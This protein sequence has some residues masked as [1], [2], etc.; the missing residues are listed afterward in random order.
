MFIGAVRTVIVSIVDLAQH[1]GVPVFACVSRDFVR[2]HV[3]V[4]FIRTVLAVDT[5]VVDPHAGDCLPVAA[6]PVIADEDRFV[7]AVGAVRF[8]VVH[9]F[10][11]HDGTVVAREGGPVR[12]HHRL[13]APVAAIVHAVV[14]GCDLHDLA[15][16]ASVPVVDEVSTVGIWSRLSGTMVVL[17]VVVIVP[18]PVVTCIF[19]FLSRGLVDLVGFRVVTQFLL[20]V[21]LF[22]FVVCIPVVVQFFVSEAVP[23]ETVV[24]TVSHAHNCASIQVNV[25]VN[26]AHQVPLSDLLARLFRVEFHLNV[27]VVGGGVGGS[28]HFLLTVKQGECGA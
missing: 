16:C 12:L 13:I 2:R 7:R 17:T 21:H 14:D 4:R 22:S 9:S 11:R 27:P 5:A 28:S 1:D 8:I 25:F 15:V 24:F 6:V 26:A 19:A 10:K 23:V 3:V 20:V 18:H